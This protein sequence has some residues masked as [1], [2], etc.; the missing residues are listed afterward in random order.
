MSGSSFRPLKADKTYRKKFQKKYKICVDIF[1][2]ETIMRAISKEEKSN[3]RQ[4][5]QRVPAAEKG[6]RRMRR[7]WSWSCMAEM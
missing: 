6:C 7:T 3:L 2:L 1:I 5:L 4:S